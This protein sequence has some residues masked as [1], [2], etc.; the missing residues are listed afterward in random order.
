MIHHMCETWSQHTW[1]LCSHPGLG[2]LKPGCDRSGIRGML[3]VGRNL[4]RTGQPL[5]T[6]ATLIFLNLPQSF[7]HPLMLYSD[8]SYLITS[9]VLYP[10]W[11]LGLGDLI[12]G[13]KTKLFFYLSTSMFVLLILIWFGF[14][15]E[16]DELWSSVRN[17]IY[18]YLG[19][20]EIYKIT[21]QL[22][23]SLIKNVSSLID[24]PYLKRYSLT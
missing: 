19:I 20:K 24:P 23:L 6:F 17:F 8:Y 22:R 7:S 3:T 18:I 9:K 11:L 10:K 16:C 12:L 21:N 13:T 5:L 14:L 2:A 15:I 4:D 1:W